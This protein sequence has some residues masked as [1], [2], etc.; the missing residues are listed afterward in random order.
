[1]I[2]RPLRQLSEGNLGLRLRGVRL[3]LVVGT[4]RSGTN[5]TKHSLEHAYKTE[6][7]YNRWFWKHGVPPT[8]LPRPIPDHVPVLV[9]SKDPIDFNRSLYR[10]W[11]ARRPELDTGNSLSEF[12]RRELIV[13]DNTRGLHHPKYRF[14]SPTDY[15]N[16]FYFSWLNW[17]QIENQRI[18][19]RCEAL[20]ADPKATLIS[21]AERYDL[22]RRPGT[23]IQ[24]PERRVGPEVKPEFRNLDTHLSEEDVSFVKANVDKGIA[25]ALGYDEYGT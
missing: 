10:F 21:V 11:K 7:V 5:V 6:V 15:W 24:I 12:I 17:Q 20:M 18:F 4:F 16:H 3:V 13:Y 9:M 8:G 22:E 23:E 19:V 14:H 1:M 2:N 25:R